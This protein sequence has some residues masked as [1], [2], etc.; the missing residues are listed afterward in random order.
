M[1]QYNVF[2][3]LYMSFYSKNLYRDVAT[4]WG[5]KSFLY[6]FML[7]S[8]VSVY[9]SLHTQELVKI[10]YD[11]FYSVVSPQL[12]LMKIKDGKLSTPENRPYVIT[13]ANHKNLAIIDTSGQ[14]KTLEQ[15]KTMILVTQTQ[16]IMEENKDETRVYAIPSGPSVVEQTIDPRKISAK[17]DEYLGY[18]LWMVFFVIFL[19]AL[20]FYRIF[21]AL[22][23]SIIGKI[24]ALMFKVNLSYGQI[25]QIM[26]VAITPAIIIGAIQYATMVYMPLAMVFY[27]V[28]AMAYLFYGI[29]ANK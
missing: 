29:M 28:L 1:Q 9:F 15:A 8:F 16:V 18:P 27:F 21:Q 5:G 4:N 19:F 3:A 20:Y 2:Q 14:Y 10:G 6:L 25:L 22:V 26:L 11:K 13:D 17:I 23:Y 24:F 12:P 7:I